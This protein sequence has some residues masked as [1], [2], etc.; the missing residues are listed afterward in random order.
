MLN[1]DDVTILIPALNERL[2]I[3]KTVVGIKEAGYNK[4]IVVDNWS[5]D[6]TYLQ[7]KNNG[8]SISF[9]LKR[10]K[11][12]TVK[13]GLSL[14]KTPY[15][16]MMDADYTYPA[17]YINDVMEL[18]QDYDVVIAERHIRQDNAMAL[19]NLLGNRIISL[20]GSILYWFWCPDICTGMWGFRTGIINS[21]KITSTNF[22]LEA[23]LFANARLTKCK[24]ARIPIAYRARMDGALS[25]LHI[26][27][28]LQIVWFLIKKRIGGN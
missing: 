7:A 17:R 20:I 6:D 11:G 5:E 16:V 18:L 2:S 24:I 21:F 10:G 12:N 1:K 26:W 19:T 22:T 15:I 4:I 23:D 13:N 9:E 14:I 27:N 3:G 28:G 25:H 8:A